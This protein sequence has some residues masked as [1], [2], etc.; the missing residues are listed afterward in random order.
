MVT[1]C[2][3]PTK[4]GL[5][6]DRPDHERCAPKYAIVTASTNPTRLKRAAFI[7]SFCYNRITSGDLPH[8]IVFPE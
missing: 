4:E 7:Q 1:Q 6:L 5:G 8:E 2:R 3:V